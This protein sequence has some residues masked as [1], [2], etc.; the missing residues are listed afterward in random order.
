MARSEP[1]T[2]NIIGAGKV[3]MTL[4]R[5]LR[6]KGYAVQDV[7][8]R[9]MESATAAIAFMG[10]GHAVA[11][12]QECRPAQ[13]WL[14]GTGDRDIEAACAALS[15][16]GKLTAH[17]VVFHCSGALASDKLDSARRAGARTAS[18]HPIRSF[19]DPA[20]AV[21]DFTGTW[22]GIEGEE[23]A[24][25]AL[26]AACEAIGGRPL[27]LRAETK[28]LYHGA[29]VMASNYLVT[30]IDAALKTYHAAGVPEAVARELLEPL[31]RGTVDN[32]F[33]LGTAAALTGPIARGDMSIVQRQQ[34]AI[35]A[36]AP[37]CGALYESFIELAQDLA[38]RKREAR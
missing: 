27:L 28:V 3:G 9:S 10:G 34:A 7:L 23:H 33:R 37:A 8:N 25:T 12:L 32:V 38:R 18:L 16:S 20:L 2:I 13:F 35:A 19:A 29:A 26:T 5:L 17:A 21:R 36:A 15:A 14:I 6:D 11:E 31:V 30:L 22:C 4:G 24:V 1:G